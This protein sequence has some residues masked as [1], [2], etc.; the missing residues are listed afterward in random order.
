MF[1]GGEEMLVAASVDGRVGL[2][3]WIVGVAEAVVAGVDGEDGGSAA[4]GIVVVGWKEA[5]LLIALATDG[6]GGDG[7]R[8]VAGRAAVA[9]WKEADGGGW[10]LLASGGAA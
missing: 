9:V 4:G 7:R 10:L 8:M 6:C 1:A 5:V 3:I 2:L